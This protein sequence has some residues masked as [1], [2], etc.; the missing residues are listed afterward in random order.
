MIVVQTGALGALLIVAAAALIYALADF[1]RVYREA[2]REDD[3][4]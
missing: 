1:A 3:D 2:V 4:A